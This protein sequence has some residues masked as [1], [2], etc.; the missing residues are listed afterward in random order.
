VTSLAGMGGG[1]RCS[2]RVG[3]TASSLENRFTRAVEE[4]KGKLCT[5]A[6][7]I[8]D[9]VSSVVAV[10]VEQLAPSYHGA[11]RSLRELREA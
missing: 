6:H 9:S 8:L 3:N 4:R 1:G 7:L 2:R 11:C 5:L 10:R